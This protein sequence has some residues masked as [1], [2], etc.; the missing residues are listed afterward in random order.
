MFSFSIPELFLDKVLI[1]NLYKICQEKM[2]KNINKLNCDYCNDLIEKHLW[3]AHLE[4][5]RKVNGAAPSERGRAGNK[6]LNYKRKMK[7]PLKLPPSP[8]ET[9]PAN[10]WDRSRPWPTRRVARDIE[11]NNKISLIRV[12]CLYSDW[13]D[14]SEDI[15]VLYSYYFPVETI[16]W[17]LWIVNK[18]FF[19]SVRFLLPCLISLL[20]YIFC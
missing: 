7:P 20:P 10:I 19:L 11:T 2:R 4:I 13:S 6:K 15:W 12:S 3:G 9:T 8:P 5:C 18:H 14:W 17:Y 1:M 16:C